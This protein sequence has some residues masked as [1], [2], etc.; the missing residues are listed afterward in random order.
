ME[1]D[2]EIQKMGE[3]AARDTADGRLCD[4]GKDGVAELAKG[5]GA[6]PGESIYTWAP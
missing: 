1:A 3:D 5:D 6:D 2:V 4:L